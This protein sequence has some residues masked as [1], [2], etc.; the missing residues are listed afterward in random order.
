MTEVAGEV[1]DGMLVHGFTTER[2]IREKTLPALERGFAK[3]GRDRKDYELSFPSFI[4]TGSTE[5][6]VTAA[7]TGVRQQIAFY[8]STPAY[9]GVLDLHGWG[10]LQGELNRLSKLGEWQQMGTLIDEDILQAFAVVCEPQQVASRLKAR[11]G[12]VVDRVSF[13]MPYRAP[14]EQ[15]A[16]IVDELKAA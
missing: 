12:D 11:F 9:R 15:V 8:G 3:A 5:E 2:Y 16:Q 6:E 4:V 14:A 10:D 7:A 13:Y 1:A